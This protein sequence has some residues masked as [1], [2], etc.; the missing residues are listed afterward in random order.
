MEST[1]K[2]AS[3]PVCGAIATFAHNHPEATIYR[4]PNC[5]HAFTNP[6]SIESF[7]KYGEDYYEV[8]HK[9][10]F[11]NPNV[12]L[13]HWLTKNLG[14]NPKSVIDV[15]CGRGDLLRYIQ[16]TGVAS[17]L[18]GVDLSERYTDNGIEYIRGDIL[19]SRIDEKFD[20]VVSLAV[21]EHI[22]DVRAFALR[23][24]E[25]CRPGGRV[26]VMTLNDSG[27]L[28]RLGRLGKSLGIS[29]AFDRLYSVHHLHHFTP[30]SLQRL[31]REA[32]LGIDYVHHHN[33]P[34]KAIDLPVSNALSAAILKL[35]VAAAF[36]GGRLFESAYLQTVVA[37]APS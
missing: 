11:E 14:A 34:L 7:E 26:I 33:A 3:C 23:L 18:V 10:W 25:L 32:G 20:V 15:G 31:L 5:T 35:G 1:N 6:D 27:M 19:T 16:Q 2:N 22:R 9:N 21:I 12:P 8:I 13:F 24:L 36:A 17:R 37:K 30:G 4:C 28:Y 29:I